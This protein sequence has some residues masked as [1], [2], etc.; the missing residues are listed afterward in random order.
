MADCPALPDNPELAIVC[1]AAEA[2]E[3]AAAAAEALAARGSTL[4]EWSGFIQALGLTLL[5]VAA[6]VLLWKLYGPIRAIIGS[7]KF[8]IKIGPFELSAQEAAEQLGKQIEDLQRKVVDLEAGRAAPRPIPTRPKAPY[9]PSPFGPVPSPPP[10]PLD[11]PFS[12][13]ELRP[14]PSPAPDDFF[15]VPLAGSAPQPVPLRILWVD[16]RPQNNAFAIAALEDTEHSI[17]TVRSSAEAEAAL[18]TGRFD[19]I[20]SDI[21]RP[22]GRDAGLDLLRKL[23]A[24]GETLPFG[25]YSSAASLTRNASAIAELDAFVATSSFVELLAAV[26]AVAARPSP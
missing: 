18:R 4:S 1:R 11:D 3:R 16:D 10:P 9:E 6:I 8:T 22:E 17:R 21:G 12:D 15:D 20:L 19:A 24:A 23:R 26:R 7:R 5:P 13:S 14:A 25:F 2:A